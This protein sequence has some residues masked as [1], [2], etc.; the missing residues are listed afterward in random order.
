MRAR[1]GTRTAFQPPE[2]RHSPE[3]IAD[4]AQ[5]GTYT[6]QSEAQSVDVVHT[7]FS[8]TSRATHND[9]R[10][11]QNRGRGQ[12][13]TRS[14]HFRD[15]RGWCG[16]GCVYTVVVGG[17]ARRVRK[18]DHGRPPKN[19]LEGASGFPDI[20][21]G[22]YFVSPPHNGR[23]VMIRELAGAEWADVGLG[24]PGWRTWSSGS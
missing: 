2:I 4:P 15:M 1:G 20:P 6:A 19:R 18:S 5:S 16:P 21:P 10:A 13:G 17:D 12:S 22:M 24:W 23:T 7:P 9:C 14:G 3:N 8:G 11:T